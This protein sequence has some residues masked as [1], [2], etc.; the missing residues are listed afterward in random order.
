V[1]Y[2]SNVFALLG[3]R[4]LYFLLAGAAAR[5]R[6]LRPGLAVILGAVAAKLLLADVYEFP[7]WSAPVFITAVLSVVAAASI[8]DNRRRATPQ[9]AGAATQPA[10][11][12]AQP[13]GTAPRPAAGARQPAARLPV[14]GLRPNPLQRYAEIAVLAAASG[15]AF[16]MPR[17]SR[18]RQQRTH[19]GWIC[20]RRP[21]GGTGQRKRPRRIDGTGQ[22]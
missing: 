2:T 20:S 15:R 6:Y 4:A 22:R 17:S 12:A 19:Q 18:L 9:P 5:L 7:T 13:A 21:V 14:S 16:R 8:R 1:V 11:A 10:T 3:M